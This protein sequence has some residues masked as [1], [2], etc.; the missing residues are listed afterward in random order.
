[1]D[2][3]IK[4]YHSG[5]QVSRLI[6]RTASQI[7]GLAIDIVERSPDKQ[8]ALERLRAFSG[9]VKE[10]PKENEPMTD[11][12][13]APLRIEIHDPRNIAV[14]DGEVQLGGIQELKL[15]AAT[16]KIPP[17]FEI[18]VFEVVP[19]MSEGMRLSI[20][21]TTEVARRVGAQLH[22]RPVTE[23][24]MESNPEEQAQA[25]RALQEQLIP[26]RV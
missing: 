18:T 1:M 26:P 6:K 19:E 11:A 20:E 14:Y 4:K 10:R 21:H 9:P 22:V 2:P 3:R 5:A 17:I 16:D 8:T 12:P 25:E 15:H 24:V 23:G 7:I 13:H